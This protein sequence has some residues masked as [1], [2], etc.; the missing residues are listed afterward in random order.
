MARL[1]FV[2]L[3]NI[4]RSPTA[5]AVARHVSAREGLDWHVD[6]AGTGAWHVGSPPDLRMTAA[7]AK[8]GIDLTPLRARQTEPGDFLRFDHIYAMDR[9]NY[10]DLL[11][12]RP[13]DASAELHLFLGD[14]E[15]PDP[16]YG[17]DAG[18]EH[19]LNLIQDRMEIVLETLRP[20]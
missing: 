11:D 13:E 17:G 20:R 2:C 3:G 10:A 4:C 14:A 6:G 1:L 8:R 16:Y 9:N 15:V 19:V 12:L 5:D 18:F 7:A